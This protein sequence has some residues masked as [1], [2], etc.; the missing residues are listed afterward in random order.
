M[1]HKVVNNKTECDDWLKSIVVISKLLTSAFHRV[2]VH[3]TVHLKVGNNEMPKIVER[4]RFVRLQN[5]ASCNAVRQPKHEEDHDEVE[6]ISRL[7]CKQEE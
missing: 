3:L 1:A 7:R 5:D 4:E 2:R 6:D